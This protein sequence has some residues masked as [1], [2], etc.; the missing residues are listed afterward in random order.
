MAGLGVALLVAIWLSTAALQ[1]PF[2]NA[3]GAGLVPALVER[4]SQS[5]WIRTVA[6]TVRSELA[7][8]MLWLVMTPR[9]AVT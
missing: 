7:L 2:H 1:V 3:L 4:L 6:W 5:N 9:P 8:S